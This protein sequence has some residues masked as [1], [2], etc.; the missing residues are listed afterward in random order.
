MLS[1]TIL[2]CEDLRSQICKHLQ[3]YDL[4]SLTR[5][6]TT[7]FISW[8]LKWNNLKQE[9]IRQCQ[10]F[11]TLMQSEYR[12]HAEWRKMYLTSISSYFRDDILEAVFDYIFVARDTRATRYTWQY[13]LTQKTFFEALKFCEY[14]KHSAAQYLSN[15]IYTLDMTERKLNHAIMFKEDD[16]KDLKDKISS[17]TEQ[18]EQ[19]FEDFF[20]LCHAL[21]YKSLHLA[22]AALV[23]SPCLLFMN[24]DWSEQSLFGIVPGGNDRYIFVINKPSHDGKDTGLDFTM[25][26]LQR[27][28]FRYSRRCSSVEL[29]KLEWTKGFFIEYSEEDHS[30]TYIRLLK[31][32]KEYYGHNAPSISGLEILFQLLDDNYVL[33]AFPSGLPPAFFANVA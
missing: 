28:I 2:S 29:H 3:I 13:K 22:R 6:C 16:L 5:V 23:S 9:F 10:I 33:P 27:I 15:L 21:H 24:F 12:W 17:I 30:A 20:V 11:F 1:L 25:L 4:L 19:V 18:M 32:V 14:T 26:N 7:T 31:Y 8:K